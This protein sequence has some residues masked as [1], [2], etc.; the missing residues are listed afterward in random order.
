MLQN[1][2]ISLLSELRQQVRYEQEE[3]FDEATEVAEKKKVG[4]EEIP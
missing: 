4:M 2:T 1:F 3:T